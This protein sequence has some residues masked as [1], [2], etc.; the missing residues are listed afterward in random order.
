MDNVKRLG[1]FLAIAAL[2]TA[3]SSGY[4]GNEI[5]KRAIVLGVGIDIADDGSDELCVTA[6][7]VSPGNGDDQQVGTFSKTVTANGATLAEALQNIAEK[8]GKETSLGQ[9]VLAVFGES[10]AATNFSGTTDYLA[11]SDSFKESAVVCVCRGTARELLSNTDAVSQS[12]S[13][14]VAD[15]LSGQSKDIAVPSSNLL[16]F[17]RS[18]RELFKTGFLNYIYF[19][20]TENVDDRNSEEKQ[21]VFLCRQVAVFRENQMVGVLSEEETRGF[22]LLNDDVAGSVFS[23]ADQN[24]NLE[25]LRVNTKSVDI[26]AND[27][28][29]TLNLTLYVKP[30]RADSFGA[31]GRFTA[32]SQKE[33]SQSGLEQTK[34]QAEQLA[35]LFLTK[36][37]DWE[38]DLLGIHELYRQR[39]GTTEAVTQLKMTDLKYNLIVNVE[40]K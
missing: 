9:C 37:V 1:I 35:A 7:I 31:G 40:E 21:V 2:L 26:S 33:I 4:R 28:V 14:S 39:Y 10:F 8:T 11:R 30:A 5:L 36:Q 38:F 6:E 18:Q 22:A 27:G 17:A 29:V 32:K 16:S 3:V 15:Q 23:V 24:G 34:E 25:T 20:Q 19:E 12:V 13:L